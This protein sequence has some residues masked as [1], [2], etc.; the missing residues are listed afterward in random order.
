M[1]S[2]TISACSCS[3]CLSNDLE[4]ADDVGVAVPDDT[5]EPLALNTDGCVSS[6]GNTA[7]ITKYLLSVKE[8]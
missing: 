2:L 6:W 1:A 3:T 4:E 5:G 8:N 7:E